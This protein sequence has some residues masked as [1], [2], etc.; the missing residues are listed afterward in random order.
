MFYKVF[1]VVFIVFIGINLYAIQ[2]NLGMFHD[3]NMKFVY[4]ACAGFTGL[5]LS[6]VLMVWSNL[7]KKTS[8]KS[9]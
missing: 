6:F 1:V 4:S 3:E 2:W 8:A 7:A 5:L 9:F